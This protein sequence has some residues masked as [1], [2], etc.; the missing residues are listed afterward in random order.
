MCSVCLIVVC[1]YVIVMFCGDLFFW[2]SFMYV[3]NVLLFVLCVCFVVVVCEWSVCECCVLF[4]CGICYVIC[5]LY[6]LCMDLVAG[7]PCHVWL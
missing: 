7:V 3:C 5:V 4:G 2:L 1:I 6:G